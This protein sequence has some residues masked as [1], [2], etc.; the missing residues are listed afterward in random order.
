MEDVVEDELFIGSRDQEVLIIEL[1]IV[2]N[3][4]VLFDLEA[5]YD[6]AWCIHHSNFSFCCDD[7]VVLDEMHPGYFLAVHIEVKQ[8]FLFLYAEAK[9]IAFYITE[10]NDILIFVDCNGSDLIV[11]IVEVLFVV[12]HIPYISEHLDGAVPGGRDDGLALGHVK[13][14]DDGVIV[15][16]E[17]LRLAAVNDVEDI[18]VVIPCADLC[19]EGGTAK[20]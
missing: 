16:R 7:D 14:I 18:D 4:I 19:E 13:D 20:T 5:T 6:T 11:V 9:H 15:S 8:L 12:Q 17:G 10:S 3:S 1:Y 2:Y